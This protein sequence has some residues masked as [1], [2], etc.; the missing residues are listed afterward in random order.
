[1]GNKQ[2][3][4]PRMGKEIDSTEKAR[5]LGA[6]GGKASGESKRRKKTMKELVQIMGNSPAPKQVADKIKTLFPNLE[7]DDLINK[8][9]ILAKQFEKANKGDSKAF[10]L[11]RDTGGEKPSDK[12]E[13]TGKDGEPLNMKYELAPATKDA[14]EQQKKEREIL[15]E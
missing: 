5:R 10:E 14:I 3:L 1:M 8:V 7:D 4:L 13:M 6:L 11:I 12:L 9:T 2:N 15:D